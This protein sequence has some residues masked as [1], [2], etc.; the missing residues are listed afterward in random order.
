MMEDPLFGDLGADKRAT[1]MVKYE[2]SEAGQRAELAAGR[3]AHKVRTL[4]VPPTSELAAI[5]HIAA[6]GTASY[7]VSDT[8][9][10]WGRVTVAAERFDAPLD[11]EGAQQACLRHQASV[12][13]KCRELAAEDARKDAAEKQAY[14][15][16][17]AEVDAVVLALR[18]DDVFDADG[19]PR[20]PEPPGWKDRYDGSPAGRTHANALWQL[21]QERQAA[22]A[23][24]AEDARKARVMQARNWTRDCAAQV[25][26]AVELARAAGEGR[27]IMSALEDEVLRAFKACVEPLCK[28]VYDT[29]YESEPRTDVPSAEAYAVFDACNAAI[30]DIQAAVGLP[31]AEVLVKDFV[32]ID[33]DSRKAHTKWR[34]AVPVVIRHPWIDELLLHCSHEPVSNYS[35]EEEA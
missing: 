22:A 28:Q 32:R 31:D 18:Y 26:G 24:R 20:R 27:D 2:L 34:T 35:D 9:V 21:A 16:R 13:A 15:E 25:F 7:V 19:A 23:V 10:L 33:I 1:I 8:R 17:L 6:D 4:L 12:D 14:A 5:A 30:D 3:R 29:F 11:V